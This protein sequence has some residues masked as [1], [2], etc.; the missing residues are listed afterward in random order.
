MSDNHMAH[1]LS[2]PE[3]L[4]LSTV[5]IECAHRGHGVST[6][7]G[8]FCRLL[9]RDGYSAPVLVTNRHV[10]AG[11]QR[12]RL[13][14]MLA[15]PAGRPAAR[16]H[17]ITLDDF[18]AR[19]LPHPERAVD[20]CVM[21]VADLVLDVQQQTRLTPQMLGSELICTPAELATLSP[22]ED[23]IVI[24]YPNGIWDA[25]NN[26]PIVRKG[27]TATEPNVDYAGRPEFL[28][29][30][31]WLPG[32]SGAPVFLW[33]IGSHTTRAGEVVGRSRV[34]LLGVLT[35]SPG[36]RMA[37]TLDAT[38]APAQQES[39]PFSLASLDIGI[40][41]KARKLLELEPILEAVEAH[42]RQRW[43]W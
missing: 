23:I 30:R 24:S 13:H 36:Q 35:S 17:T 27:I 21:P 18:Q 9:Q 1:T 39:L 10:V 14:L 25:V 12:G 38:R 16:T 4:T 7:T 20:L 32:A 28:I 37:G 6:G 40:V 31:G 34:R 3:Q 2:L 5:R 33:N 8:F 15:D 42:G 22:I 11:A 43:T 29:D 26:R 19:W 41:V